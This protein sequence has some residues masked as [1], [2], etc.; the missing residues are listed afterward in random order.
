MELKNVLK[1]VNQAAGKNGSQISKELNITPGAYSQYLNS[2]FSSLVR[3]I[4]ICKICGC[5]ITI[6]NKNGLNIKL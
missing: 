6:S 5:E 4:E 1:L 2:D 3:F